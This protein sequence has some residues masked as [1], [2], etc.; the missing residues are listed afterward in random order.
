[1]EFLIATAPNKA[2]GVPIKVIITLGLFLLIA[3]TCEFRSNAGVSFSVPSGVA[4]LDTQRCVQCLC[5]SS[6]ETTICSSLSSRFCEVV[7][8][9]ENGASCEIRGRTVRNGETITV[10]LVCTVLYNAIITFI[11]CTSV[12]QLQSLQVQQQRDCVH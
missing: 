12:G 9:P 8:P 10:S 7:N 11:L 3:P 6:G 1:M 5:Q 2:P 4:I